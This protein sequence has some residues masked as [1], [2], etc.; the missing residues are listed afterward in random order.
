[1]PGS[2]NAN[3]FFYA[4]TNGIAGQAPDTLFLVYDYPPLTHSSF[5]KGQFVADV[6][7]P[8][9]VLNANGTETEAPTKI[10]VRGSTGCGKIAPC[11]SAT[12]VG[13]FG[14]TLQSVSAATLGLTVTLAIQP[15]TNSS[16]PH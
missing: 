12:A 8:L 10:Q 13:T 1:Q 4:A 11:I 3:S 5:A 15:S 14:S 7:V 2:Q 9:G 6:T 16:V